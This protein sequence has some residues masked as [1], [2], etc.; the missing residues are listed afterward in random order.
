[1]A[2]NISKSPIDHQ[3]NIPVTYFKKEYIE[4]QDYNQ[5]I[6]FSNDDCFI[7]FD[8]IEEKAISIP[9]SPFGS[10]FCMNQSINNSS[11]FLQKVLLELG[12]KNIKEIE[13][14]LP[15]SIYDDFES[16]ELYVGSG[17]ELSY[18]DLNQHIDL[19]NTWEK[20]IHKMQERKLSSLNS[21]GF[22]FRKMED[23][24]LEKAHNFITVCRQAQGLQIN[25]PWNKL[26]SLNDSLTGEYECFGVF[27]D[28]KISAIC[29]A[30]NV[31]S[32]IAYYYLPATSPMFRNQSPMVLLIAGM[33]EYYRNKKYKY[34]DLG[35]SSSNGITQET[36]KL[37]KERMG[38]KSTE[39]PCLKLSL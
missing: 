36:L 6:S 10:I 33:V 7:S 20:S 30:V 32:K 3:N 25:I 35:V 9:R 34:L 23:N 18:S 21:E 15:P 2:I 5:F 22:V 4:T 39:K 17:F 38:A 1:M 8:L 27:R 29:I 11:V 19:D 37:F 28:E 24:E 26:K 16:A 13:I 14:H 12:R 31:T